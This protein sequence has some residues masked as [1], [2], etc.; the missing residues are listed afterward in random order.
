M[1]QTR[2]FAL[3]IALPLLLGTGPCPPEPA[4]TPT[5]TPSPTPSPSPTPTPG[6]LPLPA[7]DVYVFP[8]GLIRVDG[9]GPRIT[10]GGHPHIWKGVSQCCD[11]TVVPDAAGK[12]QIR[13]P[14]P[15]HV[16]RRV[17]REVDGS[18]ATR[19]VSLMEI[20]GSTPNSRWPS[21]GI[22]VQDYFHR[23]G[24]NRNQFRLAPYLGDADHESEWADIGGPYLQHSLVFNQP[25]WDENRLLS[26]HWGGLGGSTEI[27][28]DA[29]WLKFCQNNG[30]Q[31]CAW[32]ESDVRAFGNTVTPVHLAFLDKMVETFGCQGHVTWGVGNEEA[33]LRGAK[34]EFFA[35]LAEEFRAAEQRHKCKQPDGS[36]I[37]VVH[38]ISNNAPEWAGA[39]AYDI[40]TTHT[41]APLTEPIYGSRPSELNEF[42]PGWEPAEWLQNYCRAQAAGLSVW[43]WRDDSTDQ[44]LEQMLSMMA[45]GCGAIPE[46]CFVPAADD[47]SWGANI[48][49]AGRMRPALEA[50]EAIVGSR[51]GV[52]QDEKYRT[53]ALLADELR[54]MKDP[55][56]GKPICASG[57]WGDATAI[58][59]SLGNVTEE[60]HAVAYTDGCYS[61]NSAVLPKWCW[62]YNGAPPQPPSTSCDIDPGVISR[63]DCKLHQ[64]TNSVHDCTP[65]VNGSPVLPEGDPRRSA[66]E[67]KA[68]AGFPTFTLEAPATL[69]LEPL[70]NPYQ[71]RLR[72]NGQGVVHCTL[73]NSAPSD[74]C[75]SFPVSR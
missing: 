67:Q 72:G 45:A 65:K 30:W 71:F 63:I 17:V 24:A 33:L 25:W 52:S 56:T 1:I 69:T 14:K 41:R 12:P 60:M 16:N 37:A 28:Y 3:L 47:P 19:K 7:N 20:L 10:R 15:L 9:Q 75:R 35:Q 32:P 73:P 53:N 66:C 59:D 13:R 21:M 4:P 54:K 23:F 49:C 18:D 27:D 46:Q 58:F 40:A 64:A 2:R 43:L 42:N 5:P 31:N 48:A 8:E 74:L 51:C 55:E 6:P 39:G 38:M 11:A 22:E 62:L 57:P 70:E 61:T 26:W 44:Q 34:P 36:E 68:G 50:A 29:W